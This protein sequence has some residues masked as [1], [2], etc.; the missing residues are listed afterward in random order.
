MYKALLEGR[1]DAAVF[2]SPVLLYCASHQGSGP[3]RVVGPQFNTLPVAMFFPAESPLRDRVDT[4]LTALRE[5]GTYQ[6]LNDKWFGDGTWEC[7]A[8]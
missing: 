6:R 5:N 2:G 4:A 1:V 8:P 7:S 3:V